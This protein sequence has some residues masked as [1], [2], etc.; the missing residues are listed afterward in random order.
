M[1][2]KVAWA[3]TVEMRGGRPVCEV[4]ADVMEPTGVQTMAEGKALFRCARCKTEF[5][6]LE[7]RQWLATARG[8]RTRRRWTWAFIALAVVVL[9]T[10]TAVMLLSK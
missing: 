2:K 1:A 10:V 6:P 5:P 4:C 7:A 3:G 9:V 8:E